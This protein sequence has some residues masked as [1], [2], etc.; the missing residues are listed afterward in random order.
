MHEVGRRFARRHGLTLGSLRRYVPRSNDP[1]CSAG[2]GMGL[3]MYLGPRLAATGGRSALQ[4]CERLPTRFRAYTCVHGI[5]HALMRGYHGLLAP[6]V[7]ACRRLGPHGAD[8][9]Q[10]AFHDYWI[11][12]RGDDGTEKLAGAEASPRKLCDGRLTY[13]RPCWYRYFLEQP[14]LV[15][16]ASAADVLRLCRDLAGLQRSGCIGGAAV[17]VSTRPFE[18]AR[19]CE[20]LRGADAV[21]CVRGLAVQTLAGRPGRQAA[22]FG[23]C[24][25]LEPAHRR[26]CASWLGRTLNVVTDGSFLARCR[27]LP[28]A[29]AG[30]CAAGARRYREPLVTF[31]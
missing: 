26:A 3:V 10:G 13:V 5:G 24:R 9:A 25:G 16:P 14:A 19:V 20:R 21:G 17:T 18:Q 2:F 6:A 29:D 27:E 31:S 11:A 23:V 30:A 7:A 15:P 22:L 28:A 4:E 1:G 8:C 12:L